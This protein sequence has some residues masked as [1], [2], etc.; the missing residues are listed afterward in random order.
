VRAARKELLAEDAQA[1][2]TKGRGK[3]SLTSTGFQFPSTHILFK[4]VRAG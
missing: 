4:K 3:I 2:S 1:G